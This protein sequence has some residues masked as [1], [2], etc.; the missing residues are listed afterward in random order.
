MVK[1]GKINSFLLNLWLEF[2]EIKWV[3]LSLKMTWYE[4]FSKFLKIIINTF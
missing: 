4:V 1:W 2:N 3:D